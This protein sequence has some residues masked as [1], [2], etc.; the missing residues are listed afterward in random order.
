MQF[1]FETISEGKSMGS[2]D[3]DQ[4]PNL[5]KPGQKPSQQDAGFGNKDPKRP[6]STKR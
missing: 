4:N 6:D 1:Y 3:Q 5:G 2:R